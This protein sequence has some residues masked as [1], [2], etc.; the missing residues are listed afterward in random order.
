[1][2]SQRSCR[3][4]ISLA[5]AAFLTSAVALAAKPFKGATYKGNIKLSVAVPDPISFKVSGNGK[6]VSHFTIG[7]IPI[8]CQAGGFTSPKSRSAK[9]SKTGTFK[10]KLPLRAINGTK[11]GN[12]VVTGKF[13]KGG[14]EKGKVS[15]RF[16]Q[17]GFSKSC[18]KTAPYSTKKV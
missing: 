18:N 8:G 12:V 15:T 10:A 1:M 16:T 4:L 11:I 13:L 7:S 6:R 3:Q 17:R 5:A 2:L 14:K 9:V